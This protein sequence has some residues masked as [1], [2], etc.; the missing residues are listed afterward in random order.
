MRVRVASSNELEQPPVSICTLASTNESD[1]LRLNEAA[2]ED[3]L[4]LRVEWKLLAVVVHVE[5][6]GVVWRLLLAVALR[7]GVIGLG[8][9]CALGMLAVR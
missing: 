8:S 2:R 1:L 3:A 9:F 6:A 5:G 4:E 7:S